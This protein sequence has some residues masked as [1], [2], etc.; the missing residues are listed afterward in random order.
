MSEVFWSDDDFIASYE[1]NNGNVF[2]HCI[3]H[4]WNKRV[5]I[6][7]QEALSVLEEELFEM[8][9][10]QINVAA[11]YGDVKLIKFCKML[12]FV[13]NHQYQDLVVLSKVLEK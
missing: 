13:T 5:Y 10:K 8:G 3:V 12:G 11:K 6:K 9:V 2:L 1:L 7:I 4:N